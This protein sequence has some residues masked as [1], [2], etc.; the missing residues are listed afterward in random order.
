MQLRH[1][2]MTLDY[3]NGTGASY[4]YDTANRL[5]SL[6]NST[7]S[8]YYSYDYS[9]DKVGNRTTMAVTD[10][11][12]TK[13]KLSRLPLEFGLRPGNRRQLYA[14]ASFLSSSVAIALINCGS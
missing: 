3:A 12:G 7:G 13:M 1:S 10:G 11:G 4:A 6:D 14:A 9:Y 2:R 5:L 8:G